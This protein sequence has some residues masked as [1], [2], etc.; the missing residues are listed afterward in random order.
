METSNFFRGLYFGL[1]IS[2]SFWLIVA[3]L[4]LGVR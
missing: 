1:V 2:L 4:I 3:I